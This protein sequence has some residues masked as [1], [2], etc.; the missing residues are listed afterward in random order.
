MVSPTGVFSSIVTLYPGCRVQGAGCR[1]QGVRC[2]VQLPPSML[3]PTWTLEDGRVVVDVLYE[4]GDGEVG[5]GGVPAP[6]GQ[7]E[8]GG[9]GLAREAP[10]GRG[11][12]ALV[13]QRLQGLGQHDRHVPP[14]DLTEGEEP[15]GPRLGGR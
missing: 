4:G 10:D 14:V 9:G 2:R 8:P 13:H 15:V 7:A 3:P 11:G 6:A 12:G 5:G 1:V